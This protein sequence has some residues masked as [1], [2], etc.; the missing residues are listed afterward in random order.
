MSRSFLADD[1]TGVAVW[2]SA[3]SL[4]LLLLASWLMG[5]LTHDSSWHDEG[6]QLLA[7]P[8]LVAAVAVL[9]RNPPQT[10]LACWALAVMLAAFAVVALQLAPLPEGLWNASTPRTGLARDLAVA[11]VTTGA[12]RWTLTPYGTEAALWRM[13]PPLAAFLS[14]LALA[15][16]FRRGVL[17]CI[18]L[19]ALANLGLAFQQSGL[20]QNSL[21][22][23]YPVIDGVVMF[24]G[25]FINQNHFATALVIAMTLALCLAVDAWRRRIPGTRR[26]EL[27]ALALA[28]LSAVCMAAVPLTGSRAGIG[29]VVP[30]LFGGLVFTG[31]LRL[32]RLL[33]RPAIAVT[34]VLLAVVVA[35]VF[36]RWLAVAKAQDPRFLIADSTFRLGLSYLP[37]G[38]GAGSFTPVFETDLPKALWIPQYVNHAHNEFAQWWLVG[39]LPAAAVVGAGL[40]VFALAGLRVLRLRGRR[41]A[42]VLAAG[43]WMAVATA[44]AHSWVDFPLGTTTLAV[45]VALLGGMLFACLDELSTLALPSLPGNGGEEKRLRTKDP[46]SDERLSAVREGRARSAL[47]R[48]AGGGAG[49]PTPVTPVNAGINLLFASK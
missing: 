35:W 9:A 30:A 16:G 47:A 44:L 29:L 48:S 37:W 43:C 20:P 38:S 7:L 33:K 12:P 4:V 25:I 31:L 41:S 34:A 40:V 8:V 19:L 36:L 17:L 15:R 10:R 23:I 49:P 6:L 45:T 42:A 21:Q 18:V 3:G 2:L 11:G 1:T 24:G 28:G 14:G 46:R 32:D 13:L 39:G 26:R 22:R 27:Q 5:G